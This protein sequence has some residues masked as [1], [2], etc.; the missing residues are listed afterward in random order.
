M[1][2]VYHE[3]PAAMHGATLYPLNTLRSVNEGRYT[4][5]ARKYSRREEVRRERIPRLGCL[6]NDVVHCLPMHPS[7][8]YQALVECGLTP[9][10]RYWFALD[11]ARIMKNPCAWFDFRTPVP[12]AGG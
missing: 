4:L 6:W 8:V 5:E 12:G 11:I 7:R 3:R 2:Y 9:G 10:R 1:A